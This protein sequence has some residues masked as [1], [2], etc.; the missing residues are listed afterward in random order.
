MIDDALGGTVHD[1]GEVDL[2]VD[3][4]RFLDVEARHEL[5][6]RGRSGW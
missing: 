5:A 1:E 4:G 3:V 2:L 6:G